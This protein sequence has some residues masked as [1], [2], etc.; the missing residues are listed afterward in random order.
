VVNTIGAG[1]FFGELVLDCRVCGSRAS[2]R[3]TGTVH[4]AQTGCAMRRRASTGADL[5]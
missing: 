1:G 2:C 4:M 3:A 5:E